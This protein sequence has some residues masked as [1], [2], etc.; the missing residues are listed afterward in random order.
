[1]GNFGP[2]AI[3]EENIGN[4][5][6]VFCIMGNSNLKI[7]FMLHLWAVGKRTA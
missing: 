7:T 1:M 2:L 6:Y 3:F 5:K 4:I